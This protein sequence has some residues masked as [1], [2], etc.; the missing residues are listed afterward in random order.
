MRQGHARDIQE[1]R[2][3]AQ[4]FDDDWKDKPQP[5]EPND[6][7]KLKMELQ[8]EVRIASQAARNNSVPCP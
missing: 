1:T 5:K 2:N 6:R 7:D 8:E 4:Q 3:L